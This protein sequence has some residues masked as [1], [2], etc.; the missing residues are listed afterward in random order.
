MLVSETL[1]PP[2]RRRMSSL[3]FLSSNKSLSSSHDHYT[4]SSSFAGATPSRTFSLSMLEENIENAEAI[5]TKWDPSSSSY[6]KVTFIFQQS[7]KEAK[8][9]LKAVKD[10]RRAMHALLGERFPSSK[11]VLAQNLMQVAMRRLE[12]EFYQILSASRDQL[13]PESVSN[14]SS[15]RSCKSYDEEEGEVRSD[16]ELDIAAE[17]IT[18]VERVSVLAMS[19]LKSIADCMIGSGYGKECEKI[20]RVIRKSMIDEGLYHLGIQRFKSSHIN[21]KDSEA[22]DNEIKKWM[23]A[24]KIAVKTLFQGE[25]ILCDHVFSAS[26][27]ISESCFYEITKEG[28]SILFSFPELIVKTKKVPERIFGLMELHKAVSDL[29]PETESVFSSESTSA[30][31][32]QALSLLLK[33]G[34]CVRSILSD[35]ESTIQ[36][37]STKVLVPGGGVHPL[38]PKVMNY[39]AS[40][41]DYSIILFDILAD[42]PPP[43]NSSFHE[44]FKSPISEISTPAVSVHLAW[45]ILVLLCKLDITAEIYK[46]VG[47]AYLFLSNNLHYI[48]EKVQHSANLKLLLGE[49]WV[50]EHTK[51]AKLYA[52]TYETTAWSK[53]LSSLPEKS[54]E[55][56]T[57]MAKECFKRFNIAFEEAYRK[58]TSWIVEDRKLS[59]DLKVSIAQKLVPTYQEFYD[60]Y[61]VTLTEEKNLELLLRFSPDDLGNYLS[62][63]FHG[64]STSVTPTTSSSFPPRSCLPLR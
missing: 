53:V 49:D 46:D 57:E 16:D 52:S 45:L 34:D 30:I 54:F 31:K 32:L 51:K 10:L 1:K 36:K 12:K 18:E 20:Y 6:T 44:T 29:W 22:L 59:D 23:K 25:K 47:L 17:S 27:T 9:F 5:I 21:K 24:A 58:Q 42:Y 64:T 15:S 50:V 26:E 4:L 2:P 14:R 39:I 56:S 37:Y 19:D 43:T 60:T 55:M 41:A 3:F 38:T 11:L 62:D 35:F 33:L 13:D 28:A 7:R 48:V 63:L 40:L 61:L 8:E